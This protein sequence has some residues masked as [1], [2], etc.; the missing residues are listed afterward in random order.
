MDGSRENR[1]GCR[2]Q[3]IRLESPAV[4]RAAIARVT[5]GIQSVGAELGSIRLQPHQ[6]SAVE[7]L[8]EALHEFGGAI[9]CDQVGMGKTFV[10]LAVARHCACRLVVAPASLESMWRDALART[11]V[12]AGFITYERLSRSDPP[13]SA[14]DL[15][16]LDEAHH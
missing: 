12:H 5:L 14:P 7:R 2:M 9:L 11:G 8:T 1:A 10:A 6:A 15:L 3:A 4:V 13:E 16:I